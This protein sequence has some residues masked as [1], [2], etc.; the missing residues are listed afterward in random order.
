MQKLKAKEKR[1]HL[2]PLRVSDREKKMLMTLRKAYGEQYLPGVVRRLIN[3]EAVR[4][5]GN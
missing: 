2:I 1:R 5:D 4:R 3:D